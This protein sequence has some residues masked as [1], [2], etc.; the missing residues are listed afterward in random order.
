MTYNIPNSNGVL[1]LQ[2]VNS[3]FNTLSDSVLTPDGN[4]S[5][6]TGVNAVSVNGNTVWVGTKAQYLQI[7]TPNPHTAYIIT[8]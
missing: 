6:L 1:F 7:V 3:A 5:Q 2:H 4:G 8:D